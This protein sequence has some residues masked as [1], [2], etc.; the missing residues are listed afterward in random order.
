MRIFLSD[1]NSHHSVSLYLVVHTLHTLHTSTSSS[2][3]YSSLVHTASSALIG[4]A[5][6]DAFSTLHKVR[7][8]DSQRLNIYF[9][10]TVS[11]I[12]KKKKTRTQANKN[13]DHVQQ[14][15][16]LLLSRFSRVR[17]C[18]T[19]ETA[20]H[21]APPSLGFSR[22]EHWSGLPFSAPMHESEK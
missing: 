20:A 2:S 6:K 21:Q 13:M 12:P 17:L 19:P 18:A 16:L 1:S 10:L 3:T 4:P 11:V 15:L 9:R 8:G 14:L 5:R 7:N 22:Q